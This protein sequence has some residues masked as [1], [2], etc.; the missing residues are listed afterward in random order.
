MSGG[1]WILRVVAIDSP[2]HVTFDPSLATPTTMIEP[3]ASSGS[4]LKR[5]RDEHDQNDDID[6]TP[7]ATILLALPVLVGYP[8]DH[9]LHVP[10]LRASLKALR[11][12]TGLEGGAERDGAR[13]RVKG[14]GGVGSAAGET[15]TPEVEVRAWMA[16]AEVGMM[17]VRSRCNRWGEADES[18]WQWTT[19][20]EQDVSALG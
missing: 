8:P 19:G 16:L 15:M 13:K 5:K 11:R 2:S 20:V 10:G 18:F 9:P 6:R 4:G 12:C 7:A 1:N 17:V 3:G 14:D